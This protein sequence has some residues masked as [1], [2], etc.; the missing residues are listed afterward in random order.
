VFA[1]P[2]LAGNVAV[3]TGASRS[4][5][6]ATALAL[7]ECGADVVVAARDTAALERV[8][9]DVAATGRRS[10]A[11]GCD[12]ADASQVTQL[13]RACR[14]GLGPPDIMVANAGAFQAWGASEDLSLEEW[15]R[16]VAVD[17]TGVMLSC[18]A[19]GREMIDSGR[20]GAIVV[21]SSIAALAALPGASAYVA[22]KAGV[23]GLTRTLACEWAPHGIRVNAVAPGFIRRDDDPWAERPRELAEIVTRIPLARR[24]EPDEVA[25]A[26][27]FLASPAASY[28]TG[29]I[30]P[31]DGGWTAQ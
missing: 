4:I 27:A 17:L 15:H 9:K 7:A 1:S 2:S 22:A 18:Q 21:I 12:V 23:A 10:L 28:I 11:V 3:V 6:R 31:V 19:A 8:A 16:I 13:V 14:D 26:V 25:L 5:G 30:L 29:A 24:G 20:G